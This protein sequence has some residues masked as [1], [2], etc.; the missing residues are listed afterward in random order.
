MVLEDIYPFL[1]SHTYELDCGVPQGSVLSGTLF[2]LA[3]NDIASQLP[4]GVQNS[5]YVD[6]FAIYYSSSSLRHL[7]RILNSAIQKIQ[8][9]T[10]SVG[11]KLSSEKTQA[12]M[13]YKNSKWK[14]NQDINLTLDNTQI[15][16]NETIKFL[17]L[18]FDTHMNWKAHVAYVKNKCNSAM[19]LLMKL[20]HTT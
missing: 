17:G 5:L 4:Q 18:V 19:N 16:F 11:F 1:Y 13:F 14:Q 8:S 3:I 12:I 9:W 20:S 10:N 6:D 15:Q 2:A 7:Q